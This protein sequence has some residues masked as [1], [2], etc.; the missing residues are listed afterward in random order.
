VT[1]A[2]VRDADGGASYDSGAG[3]SWCLEHMAVPEAGLATDRPV[4]V[5]LD[6]RALEPREIAAFR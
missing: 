6:V 3:R 5:R 4:Y 2:C 1:L